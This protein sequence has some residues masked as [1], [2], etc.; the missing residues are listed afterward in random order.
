M[1]KSLRFLVPLLLVVLIIASIGWYLFVYDR[2]FTRDMLLSQARYHTDKGNDKL[3]SWFYN[4]AYEHTGQDENV[5]IELANQYKADGNFTKAEFTLTNAIADTGGTVE[6]YTALCETYIQQ[7]KTLDAVNMLNNIG[8]ESIRAQLEAMRPIAPTADWEQGFY[9]QYICVNLSCPAGSTIYYTL[10]G[11]F[12][13][14]TSNLY[15]GGITLAA[16]ETTIQAICI[17]EEGLI[18]QLTTL[19]YTV[20]GVIE[21]VTFT[22][23][24]I[25]ASVREI[26]M[27][28]ANDEIYTNDLWTITTFTV[29]AEAENLDD[30][31]LM[32]HLQTLTIEDKQIES[33]SFLS[34]LSKL[35]TLDLS[36]C[37]FPSEDLSIVAVLPQLQHLTLANCGLSTISEL[38]GARHLVYLD[39]SYN[40]LR[41]LEVLSPI[42]TLTEINLT[43][44]AVND[45]SYLSGLTSLTKLDISYNA[46]TTLEPLATCQRLTWLNVDNNSLA[47]LTTVDKLPLLTYLSV[48]HNSLTDVSILAQCT[49]LTE[50]S[51]ANNNV[52]DITM[53]YT[54][55]KLE[56]FDFSYNSVRTL[57]EWGDGCALRTIDGSYNSVS[58]ISVLAK[59]DNLTYVYMD[60][61]ALTSIDSIANCYHLVLVNVYGNPISDVSALLKDAN[62]NDKGIIVNYD[63]TQG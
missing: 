14:T 56:I 30:I 22:D 33:L 58:D 10:D 23:P 8:N 41:N 42:T 48:E 44:N 60:Y 24:A 51:I 36:G 49:E 13:S 1:K 3:G 27:L 63:P 38:E 50:L 52:S 26:L 28:D 35:E 15:T 62:G 54:L 18:S 32:T 12:P 47:K 21:L 17:S 2:D 34:G 6:L 20:G 40:T 46:V 5:A 61:N 7:N 4:L 39:L 11:S 9:N 16:G 55:T 19:H 37:R 57:P 45:L 59:M 43:N 29:P 25:E 53:L 31:A